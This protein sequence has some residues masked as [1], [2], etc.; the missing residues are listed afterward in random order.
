MLCCSASQGCSA[1]LSSIRLTKGA[2]VAA[3]RRLN[4]SETDERDRREGRPGRSVSRSPSKIE[5]PSL[6]LAPAEAQ[7]GRHRRHSSRRR[8]LRKPPTLATKPTTGQ[9][10]RTATTDPITPS[11]PRQVR[12]Q[13]LHP[14]PSPLTAGSLSSTAN[15]SPT[16]TCS[17][18]A[19]TRARS[20]SMRC[21]IWAQ[22]ASSA[23]TST[24]S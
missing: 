11:D 18:S 2:A 7:A 6:T 19:P 3:G 17:T 13:K 24:L 22:R 10:G 14:Q 21:G 1:L 16:N 12:A 15:S 9:C 20:R 23:L 8:L 4:S 5:V